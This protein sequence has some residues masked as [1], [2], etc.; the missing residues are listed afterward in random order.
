[1]GIAIIIPDVDFSGAGLGRVT[2]TGNVPL[3]D[4]AINGPS[5]VTGD[6]AKY[7][8]V[9][10]PSN[11]TERGI[12]WSVVSGGAYATINQAGVLQIQTGAS[13]SLVTIRASSSYDPSIYAQ[14][15]ITVTYQPGASFDLGTY[16]WMPGERMSDG[17]INPGPTPRPWGYCPTPF[18][19]YGA[20]TLTP[21][22]PASKSDFIIEVMYYDANSN[23]IDT[24]RYLYVAGYWTQFGLTVNTSVPTGA[25]TMYV[26]IAGSNV[27]FSADVATGVSLI[28]SV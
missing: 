3:I 13:S 22:V 4:I 9:F 8:A 20:A 27:A 23:F 21:I 2:L 28:K 11:T 14:K 17:S 15:N 19:V 25:R 7:E 16:M 24:Y 18:D 1:M 10:T 6:T 12:V 26:N 5:S